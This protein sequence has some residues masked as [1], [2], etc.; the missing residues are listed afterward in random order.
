M[1][2]FRL[3]TRGEIRIIAAMITNPT[4]MGRVKK[5]K[6]LPSDIINDWRNAF[7]NKGP[8]I[9]ASIKG[10]ASYSN[11]LIKY[12]TIPNIFITMM[13]VMLLLMLYAPIRQN[14]RINGK[15]KG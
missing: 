4:A 12:P 2:G 3:K 13:S 10:A 5:I 7:S 15:S 11:F 6:K 14:R 9:K 8:R 1:L